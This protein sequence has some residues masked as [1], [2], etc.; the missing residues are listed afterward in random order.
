ML[1][2]REPP[3]S[4]FAALDLN[5]APALTAEEQSRERCRLDED[6]AQ[7]IMQASFSAA[8]GRD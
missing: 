1:A 4:Q 7:A 8:P 5:P 3:S 2:A 6:I